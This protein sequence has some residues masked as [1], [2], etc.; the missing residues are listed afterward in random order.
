M[1]RKLEILK[2]IMTEPKI[3]FLDEPTLGLDPKSRNEIWSFIRKLKEDGTTIFVTSHYLEEIEKNA[4]EIAIINNGMI[5]ENGSPKIL[6]K[7]YKKIDES[8]YDSLENIFLSLTE[9]ESEDY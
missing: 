9:S 7:K 1:L 6:R 8:R 2:G 4:D 5:I 3:L